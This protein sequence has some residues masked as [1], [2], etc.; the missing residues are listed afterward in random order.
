MGDDDPTAQSPYTFG[1]F[2]ID[3]LEDPLAPH[4]TPEYVELLDE[5]PPE[6]A[7]L[8]GDPNIARSVYG[9]VPVAGSAPR[10]G[11]RVWVVRTLAVIVV[12]VPLAGVL[13]LL[14]QLLA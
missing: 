10:R 13:W 14:A 7:A 8:L 2:A 12:V 9:Q 4:A 3:G 1:D 11:P 6:A 5:G